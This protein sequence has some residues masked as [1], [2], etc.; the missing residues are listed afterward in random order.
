MSDN[1]AI[2]YNTYQ[3]FI[4]GRIIETDESFAT[5]ELVKNYFN[6]AVQKLTWDDAVTISYNIVKNKINKT[7]KTIDCLIIENDI[8]E[9][10]K[11]KK[12]KYI[13]ISKIVYFKLNKKDNDYFD[14]YKRKSQNNINSI[15]DIKWF[16]NLQ[17]PTTSLLQENEVQENE[18]K[19]N[20][21]KVEKVK[22][23][24]A[25]VEKIKK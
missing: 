19:L 2:T 6:N 15:K 16:I 11:L 24:K 3:C 18:D 14:E 1:T 8:K 21:E 10:K 9:I 12:K 25:K 22:I 5:I 7:N 13:E 4:R 23:K 20:I 17:E